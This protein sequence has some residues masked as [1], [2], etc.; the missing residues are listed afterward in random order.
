MA[1]EYLY[2]MIIAKCGEEVVIAAEITDEEEE[3]I[4]QGCKFALYDDS[5]IVYTANGVYDENEEEWTFVIPISVS[6]GLKGHYAYAI[7]HEAQSLQFKQPIY[8]I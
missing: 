3:E 7:T 6:V 5:D 8:F 2:D 1:I 4:T